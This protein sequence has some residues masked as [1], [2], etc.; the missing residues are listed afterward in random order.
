M[1][2]LL[3]TSDWHLG[4]TLHGI[5]RKY[6]HGKLLAWLADTAVEENIDAILISG[7]VFD[8]A[9]PPTEA[10][11]MWCRFLVDTWKRL[12]HLQIVVIG[13]NHDSAARLQV[14]DPFLR[15]LGR[16]HV[17]GGIRMPRVLAPASD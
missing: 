7:D 13:G 12:P 8:A 15:A 16:L 6:E 5:N 10:Q 4:H 17:V 2:R 14:T 11:E 1:V 3:H 9:S